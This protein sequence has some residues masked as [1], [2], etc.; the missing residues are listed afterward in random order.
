MKRYIEKV[1]AK[2]F[3]LFSEQ[4]AKYNPRQYFILYGNTA[5]VVC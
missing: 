1:I 4:F 2:A 5:E 3:S